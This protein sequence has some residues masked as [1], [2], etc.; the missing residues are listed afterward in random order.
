MLSWLSLGPRGRTNQ[1]CVFG[2]QPNLVAR[3]VELRA[4]LLV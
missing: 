4:Y 3:Q 1:Y 2:M